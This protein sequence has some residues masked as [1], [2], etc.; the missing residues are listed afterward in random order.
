MFKVLLTTASLISL[1]LTLP[2]HAAE[3]K[4]D[5][6][7]SFIEFEINHLGISMLHGR[8]N[9]LSGEL[10][11]DSASPNDSRIKIDID[12]ASVDTNHAERDKHLRSDDFLDVKKYPQASFSSTS[13]VSNDTGGMLTGMLDMH[14]VSKE[15]SIDVI[16]IGEGK[17]PWG[18]YRVGFSGTIE[19]IR[20]EFGIGHDLGPA[21]KKMQFQLTIEGIRLE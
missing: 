9:T 2:T 5:P 19:L 7:H 13:F 10:S 15:I 20:D 12:P 11:Y 21:A 8:F 4:L 6:E 18:N 1:F 17:D 14:G 16:K 3:Y